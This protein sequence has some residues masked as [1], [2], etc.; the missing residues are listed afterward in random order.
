MKQ[1]RQAFPLGDYPITIEQ[2]EFN[3]DDY[4][5]FLL[6]QDN[7]IKAFHQQRELA[8]AQELAQWKSDGQLVY[9]QDV[10]EVLDDVLRNQQALPEGISGI[11]ST[12][13]GAVWKL[14]VGV[15]DSV[16][17]GQALMILESMKMEIEIFS[18]ANGVIKKLWID[19]GQSVVAGQT[20]VWLDE[21]SI[22]V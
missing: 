17:A 6:Q 1:I 18:P 10:S 4:Q 3:I 13:A 19:Q 16:L 8:Y 14:L 5:Q 11:D 7:T 12:V 2:T 21:E 22:S 9:Q 20:L 15:G